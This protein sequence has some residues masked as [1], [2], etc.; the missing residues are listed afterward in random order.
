MIYLDLPSGRAI[1]TL[2]SVEPATPL[3]RTFD[4]YGAFLPVDVCFSLSSCSSIGSSG[5]WSHCKYGIMADTSSSL[6]AANMPTWSPGRYMVF[7]DFA[8]SSRTSISIHRVTRSFRLSS[9]LITRFRLSASRHVS[10]RLLW[11]CAYAGQC[12]QNKPNENVLNFYPRRTVI[13]RYKSGL[14]YIGQ[15]KCPEIDFDGK[16]I[17]TG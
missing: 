17:R 6:F 7:S 3:P 15:N 12:A 1:A 2:V 11:Y 4:S 13:V 5:S 14:R 10:T 9:L 8:H 16:V